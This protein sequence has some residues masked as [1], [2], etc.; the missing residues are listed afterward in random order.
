[1]DL[2]FYK[3]RICDSDIILIDAIDEE[4]KE[5]DWQS[6]A[7]SLLHRKKGAGADRLAVLAKSQR[8]LWLR[9]FLASGEEGPCADA[10]LC[11]A[12]YLLDSGRSGAESVSMRFSGGEISADVIDAASLGIS[13]GYPLGMPGGERLDAGSA[14]S[15]ATFVEAK[16]ERYQLLPLR[17]GVPA[18]EVATV[19]ADGGAKRAR[20]RVSAERRKEAPVV[21][22][23]RV[24]SRGEL[25]VDAPTSG[26]LDA[27]AAAGAALAASASMSYSDR[28]AIVRSGTDA[29][30]VEWSKSGVLYAVARPEYIY[31]GEYH[32]VDVD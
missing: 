25:I 13:L 30:W 17:V 19:F 22:A 24:V 1:M 7:R 31:R 27:C 32:F 20:A 6:L 10:A 8:E 21:A 18:A 29:L 14:A 23:V 16:G 2:K 11:A 28:E 4:G 12:R 5:R 3:L 26:R 15:K 9:V